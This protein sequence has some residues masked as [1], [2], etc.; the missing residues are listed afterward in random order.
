MAQGAIQN[1]LMSNLHKTEKGEGID[2]HTKLSIQA[3][4]NSL[5]KVTFGPSSQP[6]ANDL[7]RLRTKYIVLSPKHPKLK[8]TL[9][10]TPKE[11]SEKKSENGKNG[12]GTANQIVQKVSD[13]IPEPRRVFTSSDK[14]SNKWSANAKSLGGLHNMGNTCYLNSS[15]QCLMH[16]PS[17]YNLLILPDNHPAK[18]GK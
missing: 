1:R 15:L 2:L 13:G 7:E 4:Q 14:I 17:L 11:K 8:Q 18:Q 16:T 3:K 12:H 10:T 6:L 9:S 5:P